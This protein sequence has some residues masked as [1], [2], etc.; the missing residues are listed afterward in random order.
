MHQ[1]I[2]HVALVVRDY[3]EAL[4]FYVGKLGFRV[5][6]D[7]YQADQDKRWVVV[8]QPG[9]SGT[10]LLLARASAPKQEAFIGNQA[11]GRVFSFSANRRFPARLPPDGFRG[12][13]IRSAAKRGALWHRGRVR[14]S[15]WQPMR[16]VAI[17]QRYILSICRHLAQGDPYAFVVA[18]TTALALHLP[19]VDAPNGPSNPVPISLA[20]AAVLCRIF[21]WPSPDTLP[22]RMRLPRA[23]GAQR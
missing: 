2:A 3:D 12:C 8:A 5:I 18:V 16:S 11:G 4:G 17:R 14:G 9:S 22:R 21:A 6:E 13:Y 7:T 15:V 20:T 23:V 10:S 1:S 19:R